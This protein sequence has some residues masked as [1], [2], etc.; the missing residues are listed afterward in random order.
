MIRV[1]FLAATLVLA[2]VPQGRALDLFW[3]DVAG[4]HRLRAADP[5]TPPL[6]QT[7]ET[8][9]IV[10]DT[11]NDRLLWSDILPLGAPLPGGVIRS[12]NIHGGEIADVV[13]DLTSPAGVALEPNSGRIYW[14]D[15][16]DAS[17]SSAVFSANMDGS[18][19]QKLVSAEWLS[20]IEGIAVDSQHKRLYFTYVNPLLDS[21]F[22]GGIARA[23][24][25]GSNVDPIVSGLIK[26]IGIALDIQS[27][28]LFW[29]HTRGLGGR[30]EG[31]IEAADLDGQQRRTILGGLETPFG[32]ALDPDARDIYWTDTAAGKIQRTEMSGILPFFED[33]A[34][35]LDSPTAVAIIPEPGTGTLAMIS[36]LLVA[37][38][39]RQ[40]SSR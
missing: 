39:T 27:E 7:F 40:R 26:P 17:E 2:L 1:L 6:F 35:G 11:A 34:S 25:D 33:V 12:A 20:E 3:N 30:L 23:D 24:L 29:A 5:A 18:N 32:V 10:V 14:T 9:G 15:L 21:L 37:W 4:I 13:R 36:I 31:A 19:V 38:A 16:G 28:T 8:R 22:N